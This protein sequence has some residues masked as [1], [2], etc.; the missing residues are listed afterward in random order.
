M[1]SLEKQRAANIKVGFLV[2]L[3]LSFLIIGFF[4][5]RGRGLSGGTHYEVL[6]ED[7]NGMRAG[8]AVQLMGVRAGFVDQVEPFYNKRGHYGVKVGFTVNEEMTK[9][10][11]KGALLSIEQSGLIG[12][13]FLEITPPQPRE[14]NMTTFKAQAKNISKG[15][16]VKFLYETGYLKVGEVEKNTQVDENTDL[17]RHRLVYRITR[18]GALMP[19]NPV[20][21]L[22]YDKASEQY[23]L[24]VLPEI[25]LLAKAPI[26]TLFFTAESPM[27]LKQ[28][29][30]IQM[31]S[32]QALK[33]TNDKINQLLSDEI[34]GSLQGTLK[35][36]EVL[37][38]E[39]TTVLQQANILF[40]NTQT[41][42]K[43]LM[44]ASQNLMQDVSL[45]SQN[46]NAIIGRPELQEELNE[47][48]SA[49]KDA[50]LAVKLLLEDPALKES[51][52]AIQ[53]TSQSTAELA[54]LLNKTAKDPTVQMRINTIVNQVDGSL[55]KLD[56]LLATLDELTNDDAQTL[57]NILL[58][59]RETAE[60]MKAISK[61]FNGHFTLFKLLF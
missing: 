39:A 57:K 3:S 55:S 7:V 33:V 44:I 12:E 49:L 27:R 38:A 47:T 46:V 40:E 31:D 43:V 15:M 45:V 29:L 19:E 5:L 54:Q 20:F 60:N 42:L 34:I 14:V 26:S 9:H 21:D 10:V 59:T 18:P 28:F 35:N 8:A 30:Q 25:P 50:S 41:D 56:L 2:L 16:P 61:K 53:D 17:V 51:L 48:I 11:V 58:D 6:F 23:Y 37:T 22:A 52:L 24:R 4:W 1:S 32:A 36:T 13:Q